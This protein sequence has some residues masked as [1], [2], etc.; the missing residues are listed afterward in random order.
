[1]T[2]FNAT[3]ININENIC[4]EYF[5]YDAPFPH[6]EN[7]HYLNQYPVCKFNYIGKPGKMITT[8]KITL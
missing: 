2:I 6:C 3:L 7:V 4:Y 1:M 5:V 8:Y